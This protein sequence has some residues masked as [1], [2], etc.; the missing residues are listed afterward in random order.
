MDEHQ[1]FGSNLQKELMQLMTVTLYPTSKRRNG[2]KVERYVLT[3]W[4]RSRRRGR[5]R[6]RRRRGWG[7]RKKERDREKQMHGKWGKKEDC[8]GC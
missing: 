1:Y 8:V 3:K 7:G 5:R 2:P 6:R 4:K